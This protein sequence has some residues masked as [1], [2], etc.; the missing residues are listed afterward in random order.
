MSDALSDI[1]RDEERGA[2]FELFFLKVKEYVKNPN[3]DT[4]K[5]AIEAAE[6]VDSVGRGYWGGETNLG[7]DIDNCLQRLVS[8]DMVIKELEWAKLLGLAIRSYKFQELKALSPFADKIV[9]FVDYGTGFVNIES[10]SWF[11]DMISKAIK[12]KI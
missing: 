8:S 5:S 2:R 11:N 1:A 7:D 6:E 3:S 10:F 4:L 12:K 9:V